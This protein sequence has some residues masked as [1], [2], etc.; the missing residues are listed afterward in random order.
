MIICMDVSAVNDPPTRYLDEIKDPQRLSCKRIRSRLPLVL[1][2]L[3]DNVF[4]VG[5]DPGALNF[6]FL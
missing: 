3:L 5:A 4:V 6:F 2:R 1:Q